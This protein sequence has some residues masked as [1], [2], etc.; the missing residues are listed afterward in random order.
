MSSKELKKRKEDKTESYLVDYTITYS[1]ES[2]N[3][4]TKKNFSELATLS[5][6]ENQ[7]I[8]LT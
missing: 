3:G 2:I 6:E 1:N 4:I 5:K 7:N 8:R